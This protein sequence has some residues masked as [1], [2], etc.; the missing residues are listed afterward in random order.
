MN[1]P[2]SYELRVRA[3]IAGQPAEFHQKYVVE[4]ATAGGWDVW[5]GLEALARINER[6][7]TPRQPGQPRPSPRDRPWQDAGHRYVPELGLD[8]TLNI[9]ATAHRLISLIRSLA[10][11]ALQIET[12]T[13]SLAK[14][15]GVT[16]R[17]IQQARA[18]LV[19]TGLIAHSVDWRTNVVTLTILAPA[20]PRAMSAPEPDAP[21][22][23]WPV[24][25]VT[26][27]EWRRRF[28][29]KLS[30]AVRQ[31]ARDLRWGANC[32]SPINTNQ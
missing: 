29:T 19:A 6:R 30:K 22:A 14:A 5:K 15:L 26:S 8:V 10:G 31:F 18:K 9:H 4:A 28:A 11:R 17:C 32:R 16:R 20:L 3:A 12:L 24:P 7:Q 2:I 1:T 21:R 27:D 23:P 13:V 25:P